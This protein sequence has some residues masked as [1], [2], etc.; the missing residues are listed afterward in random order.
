[1]GHIP[2]GGIVV[3]IRQAVRVGEVRPGAAELCGA[4]IHPVHEGGNGAAYVF[5]DDAVAGFV[6]RRPAAHK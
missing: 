2:G 3:L 1:M 4:G 5:A 6:C